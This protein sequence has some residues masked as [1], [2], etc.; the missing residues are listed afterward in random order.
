MPSFSIETP[1]GPRIIGP[2]EPVF[3]VAELSGN[4]NGDLGRARALVDAAIDA[5]ADA[6]KLQ[7]YTAD[8]MTIDCNNDYFRVEVNAAW[9]GHTLYSLYQWAYTPWH[10]QPELYARAAARGIPLFSSPFDGSAVDFLEDMGVALHKVASLEIGDL[11]LLRRI[12]ATRKP[13]VISRGMASIPEI[14]RALATLKESGAP[15][16]ALLHCVS[17]YPAALEEM[18]LRTISDLAARFDVVPGLSDHS[19]G[20]IAAV[21]SVALGACVIEKHFTLRRADGGPDA[22]FSLE[23]DEFREMVRQVRDTSK[24]LGRPSYEPSS[25]EQ[26]TKLYRR[27][28]FV[29]K[30]I[31]AGDVFTPD[32]VR[33]IRP[34]HGLPPEHLDQVIGKRACIALTRGTPLQAEHVAAFEETPP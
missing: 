3:I 7:T 4:H 1:R 20:T 12:G 28:L 6:I 34:G 17:S 21:G 26:K 11:A 5:G 2:G 14:T 24:A 33:V 27:S 25:S 9:A 10:W 16:I 29:V 15:A 19:L 18:N 8:T 32:N 23:P 22:A 13:V 31:A 30:N